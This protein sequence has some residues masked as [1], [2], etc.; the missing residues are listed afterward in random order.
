M[1]AH[2]SE[3]ERI[4]KELDD[5]IKLMSSHAAYHKFAYFTMNDMQKMM[6]EDLNSFKQENINK[7]V[8]YFGKNH[9]EILNDQ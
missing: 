5:D 6:E 8:S 9:E 3:A 7:I 4:S 1:Q 2:N